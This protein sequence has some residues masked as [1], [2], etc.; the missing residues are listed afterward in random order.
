MNGS[1]SSFLVHRAFSQ[2]YIQSQ[3][4]KRILATAVASGE[5]W[6][7]KFSNNPD[8]FAQLFAQ[9]GF[10]RFW[11]KYDGRMHGHLDGV[12]S[13]LKP[14]V[15]VDRVSDGE[16]SEVSRA[17]VIYPLIEEGFF[18]NHQGNSLSYSFDRSDFARLSMFFN[19]LSRIDYDEFSEAFIYGVPWCD[20]DY[21]YVKLVEMVKNLDGSDKLE[22]LAPFTKPMKQVA[23]HHD[24]APWNMARSENGAIIIVDAEYSRWG[25]K[26]YDAMYFFI[27][28]YTVAGEK[29]LAKLFLTVFLEI[30][31]QNRVPPEEG[32]S[33]A[34]AFCYRI[35]VNLTEFTLGSSAYLRSVEL[36]EKFR[37]DNL[38]GLLR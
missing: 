18:M 7:I 37:D 13:C 26:W 4:D 27:Q 10:D 28:L 17:A 36:F 15:L 24:V 20:H 11:N 34:Q 9:Y 38:V 12:V 19:H 35:A 8:V 23:C 14:Q 29:E 3:N 6:F 2:V 32:T 25:M 16:H 1:F 22:L 31:F 5:R 30:V 33:L 21:Y